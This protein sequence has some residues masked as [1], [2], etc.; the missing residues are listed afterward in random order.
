[1]KN[2][3]CPNCGSNSVYTKPKGGVFGRDGLFLDTGG[4][5]KP[6]GYDTYVCK[7]CGL[8]ETYVN[9]EKKLAEV[10]QKWDKV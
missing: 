7:H 4:I 6:I 1:M 2:G 3:K 5:S 9:D 10:A 8:I